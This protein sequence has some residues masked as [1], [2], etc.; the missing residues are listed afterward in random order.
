MI[1]HSNPLRSR[2]CTIAAM[3]LAALAASPA[4]FATP[5]DHAPAHGYRAKQDAPAAKTTEPER[6]QGIEV[7]YDSEK[8]IHIAVGLPDIFFYE[9]SYYREKDDGSWEMSVTGNGGWSVSAS[10]Q[11]PDVVVRAKRAHPG[12]AK[13]AK[14]KKK[15]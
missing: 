11:V 10:S 5:P 6:Q 7:V 2:L 1:S 12:P 13:P 15:K 4:A 9:G 3:C 14:G 8:G